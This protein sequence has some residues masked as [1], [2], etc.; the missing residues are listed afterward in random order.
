M[1]GARTGSMNLQGSSLFAFAGTGSLAFLL[2][3]QLI[4]N[5][6]GLLDGVV[7]AIAFVI[8]LIHAFA[9]VS[10]AVFFWVFQKSKSER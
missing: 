5:G 6:W 9:A 10:L 3:V 7:S 2:L 8:A 4:M 1:A